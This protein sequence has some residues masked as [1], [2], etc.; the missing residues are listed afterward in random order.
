MFFIH[1]A[2]YQRLIYMKVLLIVLFFS[3]QALSAQNKDEREYKIQPSEVPTSA[4]RFIRESFS[5]E[6]VNWYFE[7][8]GSEKSIEAKIRKS[9]TLYS[10]EFDT[11]GNIQ[12]IELLV[13][14]KEIPEALWN[15]IKRNLDGQFS[16]F[17]VRKTQKQWVANAP[18]LQRLIK[19]EVPKGKHQT[20]YEIVII[21]RKDKRS[22]QY[23]LLY[24]EDGDMIRK[25]KIIENSQQHL[26]Y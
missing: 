21:G 7:R 1:I 22:D 12:D 8:N 17:K 10:I 9:K 4:L 3:V 20:N 2:V 13:K 16:R 25:Q 5:E 6:K 19:G 26:I 24:N 14:I 18:D 15:T 23:E 11:L